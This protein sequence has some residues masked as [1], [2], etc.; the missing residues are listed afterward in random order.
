MFPSYWDSL[1][2]PEVLCCISISRDNRCVKRY[3]HLANTAGFILNAHRD[4]ISQR[5][6]ASIQ[7]KVLLLTRVRF[8]LPAALQGFF[9]DSLVA[10]VHALTLGEGESFFICYRG[11]YEQDHM[12]KVF[13][14]MRI[15]AI[16]EADKKTGL[17]GL[18]PALHEWLIGKDPNGIP[19]RE[20]PKI[21]IVLGPY[22]NS[23]WATDG[24]FFKW[25]NLPTALNKQ[26]K[27][28]RKLGGE[29]TDTPKL[30]VLGVNNN[31]VLITEKGSLCWCLTYYRQ[32][33]AIFDTNKEKGNGC[34]WIL[35]SSSI[36]PS[37]HSS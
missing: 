22:N 6:E 25:S 17:Q 14:N 31:F 30:I 10:S 7:W 21:R 11:K 4:G 19:K 36:D 27:T 18:P 20:F 1:P 34:A 37:S 5:N 29:W 23:Y 3:S 16:P 2:Y 8:D 33:D 35:V 13:Q 15:L 12:S 26:L 9:S 32:L 28:I 24:S